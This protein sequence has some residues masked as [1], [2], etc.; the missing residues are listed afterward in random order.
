[1]KNRTLLALL[2]AVALA[3]AQDLVIHKTDGSLLTVKLLDIESI[4]FTEVVTPPDTAHPSGMVWIPAESFEMGS[5]YSID[6]ASPVH[7]VTLSGFWMDIYEVTNAQFKAYC[8]A[9]HDSYPVDPITGY[10]NDYPD[11]P[12]V[13]V[14]WQQASA[15]AAWAG[16]SLP[17]EAEWEYAARGGLQGK[18]YPWGDAE[19]GN[20]CNWFSYNGP[21]TTKI[22]PFQTSPA[23]HGTLPV[24]SFAANGFG[25]YDMAGNVHEWCMDWFA[26]Y[27]ALPEENPQGPSSGTYRIMR[28]SSWPAQSG[29]YLR[30]SFRSYW[31][32]NAAR[33][34]IGFRC[35]K[36]S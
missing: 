25:L 34:F 3:P 36:R 9:T 27:S 15:Y 7:I 13:N 20:Q 16:K 30:V 22:A 28:G 26:V 35:V 33:Y 5:N 19:P 17:T 10:F 21:L 11:Y 6:D 8:D 12:V 31:L 32:P 4:T 23:I 29:E 24:G 18:P 14:T 2:F 1:M